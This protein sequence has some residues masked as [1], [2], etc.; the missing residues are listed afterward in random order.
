MN[1]L[2]ESKLLLNALNQ[3]SP[4][5]TNKES[6]FCGHKFVKKD[7]V[8]LEK[9]NK[10]VNEI[11]KSK[12]ISVMNKEK[13]I[14]F[15]EKKTNTYESKTLSLFNFAMRD[16]KELSRRGEVVE[17]ARKL[18]KEGKNEV[19][20]EK[21]ATCIQRTFLVFSSRKKMIAGLSRLIT[22][23]RKKN[24]TVLCARNVDTPKAVLDAKSRLEDWKEVT[25]HTWDKTS[26]IVN[27]DLIFQNHV[28]NNFLRD[29]LDE[30]DLNAETIKKTNFKV[31]SDE[32][33]NVQSA[34]L[35]KIDQKRE[36]NGKVIEI[37]LTIIFIATAP[38]NLRIDANKEDKRKV[39]GA[40]TALIES[41]IYE[42]INK[43]TKG[44][45]SLEAVPSAEKFYEKLGFKVKNWIPEEY[46]LISMELSI[47]DAKKFLKSSRA[48]RSL[49]N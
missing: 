35:F 12:K 37:P 30:M 31:V 14:H 19:V 6:Y 32:Q 13:M 7:G 10:V 3:D 42:S 22:S 34:A 29:A 2:T 47:E 40:A 9:L 15:F 8:S 16:R 46:G 44:A 24:E 23:H 17:D 20:K 36:E 48:G 45:V 41:A 1:N 18:I 33:G 28:I 26:D 11:L 43:G 38:W 39:E 5:K 21:A 49:P 4:E 25:A 27:K